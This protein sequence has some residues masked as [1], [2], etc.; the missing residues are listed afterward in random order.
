MS[1]DTYSSLKSAITD[2]LQGRTDLATN[3]DDFIDL[4]EADFN[5]I[6]RVREMETSATLTPDSDGEATLPS[7]Y[8]AW[9]TVTA[10]TDPR[11]QLGYVAPSY[12]E[13][14]YGDR[15]SGYPAFFTITGS[16]MLVLPITTYDVRLDYY[17]KIDALSDSNTTNWLLTKM[18]SAYLF[19]ALKYA[20]IYLSAD[21]E[22]Q[23]YSSLANAAVEALVNDDRQ[24]RYA[25]A[26]ARVSGPTP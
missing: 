11:I 18:P 23:R 5:R 8:L 15:A 19:M 3:V 16:T 6:I 4:A 10:L 20:A 17:E 7:D 26:A 21:G 25:R 22:A 2:W 24:S 1:L 13:D 9:R 14:Q 12:M